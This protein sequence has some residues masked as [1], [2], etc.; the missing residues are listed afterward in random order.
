[1]P[2]DAGTADLEAAAMTAFHDEHAAV[3]R[4]Y[5]MWLTGDANHAEDVVRDTL[6]QAR[7]HL[8]IV[9]HAERS[10]RAWLFTVARNVLIEERRSA[11]FGIVVGSLDAPGTPKQS[12]ADEEAAT[13][14]RL[15]IAAA[16]PPVDRTSGGG[17]ALLLPRIDQG[18][19]H[20]RSP[21]RLRHSEFPIPRG[22][23]R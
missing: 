9:G 12:A 13:P 10:V 15:P 19:D 20:R 5:P 23:P 14:D 11:R 1:M 17:R 2:T 18:T 8:E 6:L 22:V 3:L 21:N 4:G 7:Q 16:M